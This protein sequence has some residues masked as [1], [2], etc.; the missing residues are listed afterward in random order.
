MVERKA[1]RVRKAKQTESE[2][3]KRSPS[4]DRSWSRV[5]EG[6]I[7]LDVEATH[8]KLEAELRTGPVTV[9]SLQAAIDEAA[10]NFVLA[11]KLEAKARR[12]YEIHKEAHAEWLESKKHDARREL[13]EAKKAQKLTKQITNDMV[14]DRIR[15]TVSEYRDQ[16]E[17]V[18]SFQ[19]AVHTLERLTEA[20]KIRASRS[21]PDQRELLKMVGASAYTRQED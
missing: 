10:A 7:E 6:V 16:I 18:R 2:P 8:T 14:L 3:E 11:A 13:E 5:I 4:S 20:W 12:D 9:S 17:R 1:R 19:A 21:L 15:S